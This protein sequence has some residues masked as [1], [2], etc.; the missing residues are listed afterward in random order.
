MDRNEYIVEVK[1]TREELSAINRL[2][3]FA[4]S[5]KAMGSITPTTAV[6]TLIRAVTN[7][8]LN[9]EYYG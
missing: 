5:P 1:V 8:N 7:K 4:Y 6:K 9:I 3:G 2:L